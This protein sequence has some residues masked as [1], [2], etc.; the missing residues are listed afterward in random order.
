MYSLGIMAYI[1]IYLL[2]LSFRFLATTIT[3][4]SDAEF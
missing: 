4:L 2:F 3:S 1:S